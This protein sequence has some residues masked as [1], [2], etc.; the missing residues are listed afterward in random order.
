[1]GHKLACT[2]TEE[3]QNLEILVKSRGGVILFEM[4]KTKA[5]ISC[6]MTENL[7]CAFVLV[8]K[9]WFCH[10]AAHIIFDSKF[11]GATLCSSCQLC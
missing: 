7:I 8:A 5:L 11:Y 1:M 4:Q 2:D 9:I 6:A 3:S 10:D